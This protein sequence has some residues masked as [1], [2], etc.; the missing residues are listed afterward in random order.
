M[1]QPRLPAR[2]LF[3][4]LLSSFSRSRRLEDRIR[5]LSSDAV[6]ATDPVEANKILE[7]L[8]SALRS[9]VGRLRELAS[10]RGPA[11]ERRRQ[12]WPQ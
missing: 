6:A 12:P 4:S 8:A 5:K 9:H 11:P 10:G 1:D 3:G 7:E 2:T